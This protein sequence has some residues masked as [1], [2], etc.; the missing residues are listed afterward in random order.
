MIEPSAATAVLAAFLF[1][2][3]AL[4]YVTRTLDADAEDADPEAEAADQ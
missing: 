3:G 1:A 4:A 2:I